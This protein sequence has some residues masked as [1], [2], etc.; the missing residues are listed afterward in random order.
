MWFFTVT[1]NH[2]VEPW[3]PDLTYQNICSQQQFSKLCNHRP[4]VNTQWILRK[5]LSDCNITYIPI[6]NNNFKVQTIPINKCQAIY[7]C[8]LVF[9]NSSVC[10]YQRLTKTIPSEPNKLLYLALMNMEGEKWVHIQAPQTVFT[11]RRYYGTISSSV[12]LF[13]TLNIETYSNVVVFLIGK[14]QYLYRVE[15]S[16]IGDAGERRTTSV[17]EQHH[18][19]IKISANKYN[20]LVVCDSQ[21]YWIKTETWQPI[22]V[23][24]Q[25]FIE[26]VF[27]ETSVNSYISDESSNVSVGLVGINNVGNFE[28]C[29]IG[30]SSQDPLSHY[31]GIIT[32]A[33]LTDGILVT[34]GSIS[35]TRFLALFNGSILAVISMSSNDSYVTIDTDFCYSQDC[36]LMV[37]TEN[38]I[39]VGNQQK[40]MVLDR[41]TFTI[42]AIWNASMYEVL[43]IVEKTLQHDN[44]PSS[45]SLIS[46]IAPTTT[47][48][49]SEG[50]INIQ[51]NA[52]VPATSKFISPSV[53]MKSTIRAHSFLVTSSTA[54]LTTS[55]G[56]NTSVIDIYT[57]S[58]SISANNTIDATNA[59]PVS[60]ISETKLPPNTANSTETITVLAIIIGIIIFLGLVAFIL[61]MGVFVS[62]KYYNV[63]QKHLKTDHH[64]Q[65]KMS[66]Q[67][68]EAGIQSE[69]DNSKPGGE[70]VMTSTDTRMYEMTSNE[71]NSTTKKVLFKK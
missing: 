16:F 17:C 26:V 34:R 13:G 32:S 23:T 59:T 58:T 36:N 38:M 10:V 33:L 31:C 18:R 53:T 5:P 64:E 22:K 37:Q 4:V 47:A 63:K 60:E 43:P 2:N 71:S 21:I 51:N 41:D 69:S 8:W 15:L 49:L 45:S 3:S 50:S 46:T 54:P 52:S 61:V 57:T 7:D 68:E 20:V 1:G 56:V 42:I 67:S 25:H 11:F 9:E 70:V 27:N 48:M 66:C 14:E 28:Y 39:Y 30:P 55:I 29:F 6:Y 62:R 35:D 24:P 40:T 44:L 65:I 12:D 19:V